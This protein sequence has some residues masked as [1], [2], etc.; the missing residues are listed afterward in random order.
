[1]I[2]FDSDVNFIHGNVSF[3]GNHAN[4][5]GDKGKLEYAPSAVRQS[6]WTNYTSLFEIFFYAADRLIELY[7]R[8][9]VLLSLYP[10]DVLNHFFCFFCSF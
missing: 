9:K 8:E 3:E 10:H 6:S 5:S 4:T 2:I 7:L 1:M